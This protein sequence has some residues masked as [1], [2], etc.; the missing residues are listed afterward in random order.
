M[1]VIY[2]I[3]FT[4]KYD[5]QYSLKLDHTWLNEKGEEIWV[6]R[7]D[8]GHVFAQNIK[9]LFPEIEYE[10]WNLDFRAEKEYVHVFEDGVIH[11]TF[12][13]EKVRYRF[14]LKMREADSSA[15][16]L[17][18]L[19]LL[20]KQHKIKKDLIC[21]LPLD[22][23]YLGNVILNKFHLSLP[24][25]HTSHLNPELLN[26]KMG[27]FN[28]LKLAHRFFLKREM[29]AHKQLLGDI[30]VTIDRVDFFKRQTRSEV[31]LLNTLYF[32]FSWAAD[33]LSRAEARKKL[34]LD[35]EIFII[36]TSSRLVPEK[37]MD[38]LISSLAALKNHSFLCL[39][40]GSGEKEYEDQLKALVNNSGLQ[41]H[42]RFTGFLDSE[43]K[44]YYCASDVFVTPSASEGGPVSAI[45]AIA[46]GIPV[47]STDTG[48][49]A[50]LLKQY[51][52]GMILNTSDS[53]AWATQIER[54][55]N[56]ESLE[57]INPLQLANEYDLEKSFSQLEKYYQE[58]IQKFYSKQS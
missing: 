31:K 55:L 1:K 36:F 25:L 2:I 22:Y 27:T 18:K 28:P 46:L 33:R 23:A 58:A 21:H 8:W 43:L 29:D 10:V 15:A 16:L 14:G 39:V 53:S 42:I 11:R 40:S 45:K 49:V 48:I 50:E 19:E 9:K 47:I 38:K 5:Y 26:V 12:P 3:T 6:W 35:P 44:D 4:P 32:D 20:T 34:N 37:Q 54:T 30:A 57:I 24:F 51:K 13:A 56:G 7:G 52:A 17:N 41:N